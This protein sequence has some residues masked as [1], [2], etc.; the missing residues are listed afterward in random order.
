[1]KKN[2]WVK[3]YR[4]AK[5]SDK[6]DIITEYC[7]A[8]SEAVS[9]E[10]ISP[11]HRLSTMQKW[12]IEGRRIGQLHTEFVDGWKLSPMW[13]A[14]MV[15][16]LHRDGAVERKTNY[17]DAIDRA[18]QLFD[19]LGWDYDSA[20]SP[21]YDNITTIAKIPYTAV[22]D[23]GWQIPRHY[24]VTLIPV[25]IF[26]LGSLWESSKGK[27]WRIIGADEYNIK[28]EAEHPNELGQYK[29]LTLSPKMAVS[30]SRVE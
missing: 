8:F 10:P 25:G 17:A 2:Y 23:D 1:M 21:K 11:Q 5:I 18:R 12:G 16:Q 19:T 14:S 3:R 6:L 22:G 7:M 15:A 28:Y 24:N 27:Q 26:V 29:I 30:M 20:I 9:T 13:F 4:K